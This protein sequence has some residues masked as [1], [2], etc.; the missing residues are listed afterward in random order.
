MLGEHARAGIR[1][2]LTDAS[3]DFG[4][5]TVDGTV[6]AVTL[7]LIGAALGALDTIS[8]GVCALRA[9]ALF[10]LRA[11]MMIGAK[12]A[13]HGIKRLLVATHAAF[14]IPASQRNYLTHL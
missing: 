11:S 8:D 2:D 7:V 9:K 10:I 6:F 5:V 3:T 13:R 4:L 1:H 14:F 12:D